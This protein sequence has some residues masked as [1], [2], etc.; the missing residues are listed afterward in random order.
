M[1]F[2]ELYFRFFCVGLF[3][4]GG[5]MA[6]LPFLYDMSV[7]TGWFSA[8]D[9]ANM[10]AVSESTPGAIGV[11]MATY[12]GYTVAGP[13]GDLIAT[14]GLITPGIAVIII[15]SKILERFRSSRY[16]QWAM[17][18]LRAASAGLVVNAWIS[19]LAV[20]ALKTDRPE[21]IDSVSTF[22]SILNVKALILGLLIYLGMKYLKKIHPVFFIGFAA[23]AGV[24]FSFA[25]V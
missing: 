7:R 16:V 8:A 17:Y 11:N 10:L 3:S 21:V 20:T 13:L 14:L 5:G 4:I 12:C 2:L 9:I 18:G 1:I 25:G 6:T 23:A 15:I 24:I 19:V 22:L